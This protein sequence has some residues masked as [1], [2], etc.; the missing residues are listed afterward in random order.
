MSTGPRR[1]RDETTTR[2]DDRARSI[3]EGDEPALAAVVI[4]IASGPWLRNW[5]A[6]FDLTL[7]LLSS[8]LLAPVV[9]VAHGLMFDASDVAF[10][11]DDVSPP[12]VQYSQ[13]HWRR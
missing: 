4:A 8:I 13:R 12:H 11:A 5:F 2:N 7:P 9:L 6:E 1:W 3:V 10:W